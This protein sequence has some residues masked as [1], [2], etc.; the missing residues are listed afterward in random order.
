MPDSHQRCANDAQN[1]PLIA[2]LRSVLGSKYSQGAPAS[3][4]V[5]LGCTESQAGWTFRTRADGSVMESAALL[6]TNNIDSDNVRVMGEG[7][8]RYCFPNRGD[9]IKGYRKFFRRFG[10]DIREKGL[11]ESWAVPVDYL[12]AN[13][14]E[15]ATLMVQFC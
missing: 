2:A 14:D 9:A 15:L 13:V 5:S 8:Y 6:F 11:Q 7:H 4:K 1:V 12:L 10:V 3:N